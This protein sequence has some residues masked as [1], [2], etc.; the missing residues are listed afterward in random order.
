[1]KLY[2]A[3]F[4]KVLVTDKLLPSAEVLPTVD[5]ILAFM[6]RP[7]V[8]QDFLSYYEGTPDNQRRGIVGK[9]LLTVGVDIKA[10]KVGKERA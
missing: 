5:S 1:M 6:A 4:Y 10:L 2:R 3:I 8:Q 9:L 7:D